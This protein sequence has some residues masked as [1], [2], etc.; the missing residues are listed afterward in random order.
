M[1][2]DSALFHPLQHDLFVAASDSPRKKFSTP[3]IHQKQM[4]IPVILL[5]VLYNQP[6]C[7]IS[8]LSLESPILVTV[9][10][11][12]TMALANENESIFTFFYSFISREYTPQNLECGDVP[13]P[14]QLSSSAE[15]CYEAL[16]TV[17][18][19]SF[20]GSSASSKADLVG[21]NSSLSLSSI[22]SGTV[23]TSDQLVNDQIL[24]PKDGRDIADQMLKMYG[25]FGM[26]STSNYCK[27]VIPSNWSMNPANNISTSTAATTNQSSLMMSS[28]I[29]VSVS[30]GCMSIPISLNSSI[31]TLAYS[32]DCSKNGTLSLYSDNNC[33]LLNEN[34]TKQFRLKQDPITVTGSNIKW[35][36]YTP[37][38]KLVPTFNDVADYLGTSSFILSLS[39]L[40]YVLFFFALKFT[41]KPSSLYLFSYF[42]S[43][44]LY[45]L[46]LGAESI[47]YFVCFSSV[48]AFAEMSEIIGCLFNLAT[49]STVFNAFSF[50]LTF[51]K[52]NKSLLVKTFIY[53]PLMILFFVF[54]GSL[55]LNYY[56]FKSSLLPL[57]LQQQSLKTWSSLSICW[58]TLVFIISMLPFLLV[59]HSLL[60]STPGNVLRKSPVLPLLS[61]LFTAQ[62][63]STLLF[64]LLSVVRA[65]TLWLQNDKLYLATQGLLALFLATHS[66]FSTLFIDNV[67]RLASFSVKASAMTIRPLNGHDSSAL[68]L[69]LN[70]NV[71]AAKRHARVPELASTSLPRFNDE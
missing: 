19:L 42:L 61:L 20:S 16:E 66:I 4:K 36:A 27:L 47:Y 12:S 50:M 30:S 69:P 33:S 9:A 2:S 43:S 25:A 34:A 24:N 55:F 45:L 70:L 57:G 8:S 39:F 67:A 31:A 13:L 38:Y 40:S 62:F 21:I 53:L 64:A 41:R 11:L 52:Q 3:T 71:T 10:P 49:L 18:N 51:T 6:K 54:S 44:L 46:W 56:K 15:C 28:I 37:S 48:D 60:K 7:S 32:F 65:C 63:I 68:T 59:S 26:D 29:Y 17:Q 35:T 5:Q 58:I 22:I 1:M 14:N 23:V